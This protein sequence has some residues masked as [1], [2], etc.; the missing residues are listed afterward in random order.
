MSYNFCILPLL[1]QLEIT[2]FITCKCWLDETMWNPTQ[3]TIFVCGVS[4]PN[5]I[6][7][8]FTKPKRKGAVDALQ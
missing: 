2:I 8:F 1:L 6:V 4:N 3:Q 7:T 5:N